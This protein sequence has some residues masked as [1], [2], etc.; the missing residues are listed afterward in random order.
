MSKG[1]TKRQLLDQCGFTAE[2]TNMIL[3]YQ[4][5]LPI[6]VEN[7]DCEGFCINARDLWNQLECPQGLFANWVKRKFE[8]YRF[9]ENVDFKAF[10]IC[11]A[12]TTRVSGM[13]QAKEYL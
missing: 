1:F 10:Q 9:V 5:K 8:P 2:E 3:A 6:L 11:E 4:K 12:L 7:E 13:T